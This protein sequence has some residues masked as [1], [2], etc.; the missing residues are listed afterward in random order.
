MNRVCLTEKTIVT[1]AISSQTKRPLL[2]DMMMIANSDSVQLDTPSENSNTRVNPSQLY[3]LIISLN[4][5]YE[6][7]IKKGLE[8][9]KTMSVLLRGD[10]WSTLF[11]RPVILF[12]SCLPHTCSIQTWPGAVSS[13]AIINA[14]SSLCQWWCLWQTKRPSVA[15]RRYALLAFAWRANA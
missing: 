6:S 7:D 13:Y 8:P 5:A 10:L 1:T 4:G 11:V 14:V 2:L 9:T 12:A 15:W 3:W